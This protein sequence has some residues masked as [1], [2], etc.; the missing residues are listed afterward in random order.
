M[1][2]HKLP[3]IAIVGRPNVGKSS[4]F[5]RLIKKRWAITS[6][7]A[8][9]TR[10]RI[11]HHAK[12][13]DLPAILVDTGGLEYGKKE[14]I[15]ADIQTQVRLAIADA[16]LIYFVIDIKAGINISD[17]EAAKLLRKS[18]KEMIFIANKVDAKDADENLYE[19][20]KLG[21]GEPM[22]ISAY[23]DLGVDALIDETEKRLKKMGFKKP[24]EETHQSDITNVCLLGKPN[25]GKSSLVNALLGKPKVIVSEIPGTTRDAI[26]TEITWNN[27]KFNLIDTAG[28]RR[29]GKIERGLEK[30]STFRSLDAI[31]RSDVVC[32]ILDYSEGV[33]KQDQHI[34]S[35]ILEAGKGLVLIVNKCDLMKNREAD[36]ERMI[37]LLR[38]KYDFLPWAPVVFVSA[39]KRTNVEKLLEISETIHAERFTR[40]DSDELQGFMKDVTYK[41]LPPITA[42]KKPKFFSLEQT[43]VNPPTFIYWVNDPT[44]IHFSY[45]R[46]LENRLRER[47]P[48]TGTSLKIIFEEKMGRRSGQ[49]K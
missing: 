20:T 19:C 26:D 25:V 45:R 44:T 10:D 29:R 38:H 40:I 43:G 31:E 33:T 42:I 6:E 13:N 35:F 17:F 18:G 14:N 47:W 41:H 15:E 23:H 22:A 30:L 34:A 4:L 39:L 28:L 7:V 12:I 36:E 24:P 32:L 5:N 16:D 46:Y 27:R 49:K 37:G 11:Y 48:F 21:F 1:Q 8:G 3:I 2:E 9:T